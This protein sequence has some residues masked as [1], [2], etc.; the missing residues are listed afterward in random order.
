M[1]QPGWEALRPYLRDERPPDD[2]IIVVRGGPDT[3]AKLAMH[4]R[5]THDA[6]VLDNEPLWGISVYCALDDLGPGS[7]D[8][9]LRRFASYRVVHLPRVGQLRRAG[10]PLLPSFGRPHYTVRLNGDDQ[11]TL[12]RLLGALGPTEPNKYHQRERPGRR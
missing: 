11:A 3:L 2:S 6:Y 9:L 12:S 5:R 8:G 7:L 4:A 1:T 10:F